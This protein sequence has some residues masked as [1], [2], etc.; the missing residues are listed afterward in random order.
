MLRSTP[1]RLT[2]LVPPGVK[3]VRDRPLISRTRSWRGLMQVRHDDTKHDYKYVAK[4][5]FIYSPMRVFGSGI[6]TGTVAYW[7]LGHDGFM[8][9]LF[10]YESEAAVEARPMNR[11]MFGIGELLFADRKMIR[12][13]RAL[14]EDKVE[15]PK[16]NVYVAPEEAQA[17]TIKV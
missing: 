15:D 8:Y 3:A 6:L 5:F 17:S 1:R 16:F 12:G 13:I 14:E 7:Y 10:G 4:Q 11:P 9:H 2:E